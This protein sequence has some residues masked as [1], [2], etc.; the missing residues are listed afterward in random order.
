MVGRWVFQLGLGYICQK[1]QIAASNTQKLIFLWGQSRDR[2]SKILRSY[3][4]SRLLLSSCS[5]QGCLTVQDDCW[6][7][8]H[9]IRIPSSILPRRKKAGRKGPSPQLASSQEPLCKSSPR[10]CLHLVDSYLVMWLH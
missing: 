3:Q 8:C 4:A 5:A 7:C 1:P 10:F 9:R 6:S 2:A